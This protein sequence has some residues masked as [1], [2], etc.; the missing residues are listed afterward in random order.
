MTD[1]EAR[2][3]IERTDAFI[4]D[5]RELIA[6]TAAAVD[7][8]SPCEAACRRRL[9]RISATVDAVGDV[10]FGNLANVDAALRGGL[11]SLIEVRLNLR[12]RQPYTQLRRRKC[13]PRRAQPHFR[14]S[15]LATTA[16]RPIVDAGRALADAST[17][18][19]GCTWAEATPE[20]TLNP[21]SSRPTPNRCRSQSRPRRT[22]R[23]ASCQRRHQVTTNRTMV[24]TAT[25]NSTQ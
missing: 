11:L 6:S 14:E 23:A 3:Q 20:G 15:T 5:F 22:W 9:D 2:Q 24:P 19:P 8:A 12:R 4:A 1:E 18:G 10:T 16:L 25:I 13:L 17:L 21:G 7:P